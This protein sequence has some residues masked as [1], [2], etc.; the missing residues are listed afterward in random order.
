MGEKQHEH[1]RAEGEGP[2]KKREEQPALFEP[3]VIPAA[4]VLT[5]EGSRRGGEGLG[6]HIGKAGDPVGNRAGRDKDRALG[7]DERLGEDMA[8]RIDRL[9]KAQ[10]QPNPY[11]RAEHLPVDLLREG[12][13]VQLGIFFLEIEDAQHPGAGSR[14]G[15]GQRRA[16]NIPG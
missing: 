6:C 4:E 7:I 15:G 10:R 8:D 13:V 1:R 16:G 2:G 3:A 9:V 5:R 14:Q 12:A 11:H